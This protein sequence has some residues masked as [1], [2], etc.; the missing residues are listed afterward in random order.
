MRSLWVLA[1]RFCQ[2]DAQQHKLNLG[3][4][5]L[6]SLGRPEPRVHTSRCEDEQEEEVQELCMN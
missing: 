1:G 5:A 2:E 4:L 3:L 6:S